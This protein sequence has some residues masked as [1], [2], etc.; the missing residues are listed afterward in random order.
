M[1]QGKRPNNG[2]AQNP[3]PNGNRGGQ[4]PGN[5]NHSSGMTG[6][7]PMRA[8]SSENQR[9]EG[10]KKTRPENTPAQRPSPA[11]PA[12]NNAGAKMVSRSP[13]NPSTQQNILVMRL[14]PQPNLR[15]W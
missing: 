13:V 8:R 7:A 14:M 2:K 9:P 6:G 5:R 15:M 10:M 3:R 1:A 11:R 4:I 12:G